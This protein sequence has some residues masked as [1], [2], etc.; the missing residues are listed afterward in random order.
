MEENVKRL[1][2]YMERLEVLKAEKKEKDTE[3][4]KT[5]EE[6]SDKIKTIESSI[7]T[8]KA[9]LSTEAIEQFNENKE[10]KTFY[11]G[12]AIK[13]YDVIEYDEKEAETWAKEKNLFML[14]DKKGFEK[15]A[16]TLNLDFVTF[17]KE[18][19]VTFPKVIK[20]ED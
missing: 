1:K 10:V 9:D 19:K 13:E 3:Y 8:V 6:I 15:S 12:L 14:F 4:K 17:K 2:D 5:I 16:K 7:S 11:G 18:P 20:I